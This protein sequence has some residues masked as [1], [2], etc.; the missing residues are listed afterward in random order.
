MARSPAG[1]AQPLPITTRCGPRRLTMATAATRTVHLPPQPTRLI[2][3]EDE[4]ALVRGLLAQDDVRLLTLIG[5][6][7][8]GKTRLAPP[9]SR[10]RSAFPKASGSSI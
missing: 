5:P 4:L 3:R 1:L 6:G 8:V 7:G 9:R 10:W 2:N